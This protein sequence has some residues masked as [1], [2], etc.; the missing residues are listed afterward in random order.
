MS[1]HFIGKLKSMSI[2][3]DD[4]SCFLKQ[5]WLNLCTSGPWL[6][7]LNKVSL[8]LGS[9]REQT[10]ATCLDDLSSTYLCLIRIG[11][12]LCKLKLLSYHTLQ[13]CYISNSTLNLLFSHPREVG[14]KIFRGIHMKLAN[15][16]M[17]PD[18]TVY[19]I[20]IPAFHCLGFLIC[21]FC[22][23]AVVAGPV[24]DGV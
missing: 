11:V 14:N 4:M 23:I 1:C 13:F 3:H 24:S 16:Y 7:Q 12:Q 5:H 6:F 20:S 15:W 9:W 2:G 17:H 19:K 21:H 18:F 22:S 10:M 8:P